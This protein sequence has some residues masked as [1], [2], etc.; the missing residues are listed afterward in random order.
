MYNITVVDESENETKIQL[1][2]IPRIGETITFK[3]IYNTRICRRSYVIK[4]VEYEIR[5]NQINEFLQTKIYIW[6]GN[7]HNDLKI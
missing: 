5:E 7:T 3:K 1:E 2:T 4:N 6:K